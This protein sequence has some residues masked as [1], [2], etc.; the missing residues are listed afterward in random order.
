[1]SNFG[2]VESRAV[3]LA[4]SINPELRGWIGGWIGPV[5]PGP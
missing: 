4:N 3:T 1:L 5:W 2:E